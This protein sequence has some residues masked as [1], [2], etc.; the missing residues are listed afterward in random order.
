MT[1]AALLS[2]GPYT[3]DAWQDEMRRLTWCG[4]HKDPLGDCRM[5]CPRCGTVG[6]YAPRGVWSDDPDAGRKY[7]ACKFCGLWQEAAGE[8]FDGPQGGGAYRCVMVLCPTCC[9]FGWR[10]PWKDFGTC[11]VCDQFEP[12]L[13]EWPTD[14]RRHPFHFLRDHLAQL[15]RPSW[16]ARTW[17][18]LRGLEAA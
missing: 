8:V 14:N 11:E 10:S 3:V 13:V 12:I 2:I 4:K 15:H 9:A 5:P 1:T 6:F 16:L 18:R 7:R 17:W